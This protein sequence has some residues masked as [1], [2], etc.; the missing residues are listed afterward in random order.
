MATSAS[1]IPPPAPLKMGGDIAA[2]WKRFKSEWE[3]YEI[4]SDLTLETVSEKKRAA[5]FLACIG[6]T[7]YSVFRTFKFANDEDKSKVDKLTE[8]FD[9]HCIS[10]ANVTYERYV[11]HQR[12]QQ[13]GE[14]FDDFFADLRK[15]ASTCE[16]AD[17]EDSLIRD[18]IIIGIRDEPTRR[19]LL[20][21]RKLSLADAA[22]AC[23]ASEAT[24][25]RLRAMGGTAEIDALSNTSSSFRNR[26]SSSKYRTGR[27]REQPSRRDPSNGR[28]CRYCD[29]QHGGSKEDCPAYGQQCRKC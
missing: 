12:V 29:R 15:M 6:T 27:Q 1:T 18:R 14:S 23:K 10:E 5:V 19:K 8:A 4:A 11:F 21:I 20:Q 22:Q 28:R 2:D 9:K 16:F 7:A 3:N 25:R 26:R 13:P 24:S 17:L